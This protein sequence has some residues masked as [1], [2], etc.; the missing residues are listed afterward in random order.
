MARLTTFLLALTLLFSYAA[1]IPQPARQFYARQS[2]ATDDDFFT[3]PPGFESTTPGTILAHRPFIPGIF[4][5]IQVPVD[6]YQLLFRSTALDGSA[7]AGATTIFVPHNTQLKDRYVQFHTAYDTSAIKCNPSLNYIYNSTQT[8]SVVSVEMLYIEFY[9][10]LGY[11]VASPDFE[12]P[13]AA[14][15]AGILTGRMVLDSMKAINAFHDTIGFTTDS[16]MI[17]GT[18]YS[19]G[20]IAC[21]F[22]A[23]LQASYAPQLDVKLWSFG[24]IVAK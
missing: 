7:I 13:D 14:F 4:G 22:A 15:G 6:G 1:A 10:A 5:F 24:G 18:G 3:P 12:G 8:N 16:P 21:G 20:S 19:G 17:V 11:I 2:S 23:E 9:L